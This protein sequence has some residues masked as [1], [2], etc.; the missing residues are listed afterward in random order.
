MGMERQHYRKRCKR[1]DVPGEA[2]YLTFSCFERRAFLSKDRSR[3]WFLSALACARSRNPF[4][5]WAYVIM[6]EH[7]HLLIL[8]HDAITISSIL[9]SIKQPVTRRALAWMRENQPSFLRVMA[10]AQPNG[11]VSHRFWQRGGGYDRNLWTTKETHEKL[12]YIHENPVRR[13]LV[14]RAEDWQWSSY[15]AWEE[16]IDEPIAIDRESLPP[17]E[18]F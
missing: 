9:T 8:P 14:S 10:D 15:R 2:H 6:P 3:Q 4:D 7:V 11:K 1:W 16:G 12:C 18:M 17:L 13:G 5:L